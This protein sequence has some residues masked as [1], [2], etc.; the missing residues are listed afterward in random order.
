MK[1]RV[2]STLLAAATICAVPLSAPAPATAEA[3]GHPPV[4]CEFT[5]TPENT[6]ARPVR[7]PR[8]NAKSHGTVEAKITTNYGTV[9]LLLDRRNAPCAVH[10]LVH[11]ARSD[12]Y[13]ASRCW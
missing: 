11:L 1:P 8:P 5:P 6:A 4:H 7:I 13:D 12:F 2:R 9:E 10:N 3:T